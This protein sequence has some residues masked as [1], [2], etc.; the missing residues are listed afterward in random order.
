MTSTVFTTGTVIESPWLNDVNAATYNGGAVYTPAGTGAIPTTVQAKLR[1]YVSVTDFGADPTGVAD[2]TAAFLAA[3]GAYSTQRDIY[4]PTGTYKITNTLALGLNKRLVGA[5]SAL[6][7]L[8]FNSSDLFCITGDAYTQIQGITIQKIVPASRT[9]IASYTPTTSNGFRNGTLRD[10]VIIDFDVGIGSTQGL[11]QGLMF[12]NEYDNVRIYNATIAVEMGSGSNTNTWINCSFWDCAT[13]L[14]L[15]NVSSQIF[16]GCNFENST[17]YDF[18]VEDSYNVAFKTC[19]FEPAVGGT[20]DDSTGSFDTCHSTKFKTSTTQFVTYTT[21]ST[22]SINDFTD[23]NFGGASSYVTQWYARSGDTT[24]YASKS[25]LRVRTGTAKA[26][27]IAVAPPYI[28][29]SDTNASLANG[30][31][32]TIVALSGAKSGLYQVYAIIRASG[33]PTNY[34][35]FG[36]VS[37]NTT[38]AQFIAGNNGT[39]FPISISGTNVIVTNGTGSAAINVDYG[40]IRIGAL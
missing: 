27:E 10:V 34:S 29:F 19:Y 30:A 39:P 25:N 24:G 15:N 38:G 9:G 33:N 18:I 31:T 5:G 20:F 2:S 12:N 37:W 3:I 16:V 17:N 35:S 7:T 6:V 40:Y 36:V 8:K 4:V 32:Q 28:S 14:K 22:I 11:T 21:N 23:Y 26:D 13:A 1:Q